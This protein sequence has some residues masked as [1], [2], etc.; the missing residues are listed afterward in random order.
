M[1]LA[2][3]LL[4]MLSGLRMLLPSG[5]VVLVLLSGLVSV[6][7]LLPLSW[8]YWFVMTSCSGWQ[9]WLRM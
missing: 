8:L 4:I 3:T 1:E 9:R 6:A 2:D 7:G 5:I